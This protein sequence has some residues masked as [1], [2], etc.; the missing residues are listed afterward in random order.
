MDQKE[1]NLHS[2]LRCPQKRSESNCD[3]RIKPERQVADALWYSRF[4]RSRPA[5]LLL[6]FLYLPVPSSLHARAMF[7]SASKEGLDCIWSRRATM[8]HYPEVLYAVPAF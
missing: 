7:Y 5:L 4:E 3:W 1:F 2:W 8:S 6:F